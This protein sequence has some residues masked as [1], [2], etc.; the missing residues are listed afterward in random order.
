MEKKMDKNIILNYY[1]EF[2]RDYRK[3][4][5]ADIMHIKYAEHKII[6]DSDKNIVAKKVDKLISK[7]QLIESMENLADFASK[8]NAEIVRL[9]NE[10]EKILINGLVKKVDVTHYYKKELDLECSV[11]K[12]SINKNKKIIDSIQKPFLPRDCIKLD[13]PI[14]P[15]QT[16]FIP[17]YNFIQK[18]LPFLKSLENNK[19]K[20]EYEIAYQSY[21]NDYIDIDKLNKVEIVR[22]EEEDRLYK[23]KLFKYNNKI[24]RLQAMLQEEEEEYSKKMQQN[25]KKIYDLKLNLSQKNKEA[26]E[27]YIS[28][29]LEHSSYPIDFDKNIQINFNP[30]LLV[31]DY[32]LPSIDTFPSVAE[33]KFLKGHCTAIP[34][35]EK[36][37]S[38]RY[39]NTLYQI[40]LRTLYEIFVDNNLGHCNSI[41]F[42]GWVQALNKANGKIN[43]SCIL[44]IQV[45]RE[46]FLDIDFLNVSSK[47]CFKALKG[48]ACS[49]LS[50]ITAIKPIVTLNKS[51][52]RF[53]EHYDVDGENFT[54]LALMHW[55]DFEHLI[56]ELFEKEFS[57]SGGEVKVTRASRDGGVDAVVFD[58]DPIRGGKLVIQAK[59]YT[60]TVGVSAVRDLFGTVL[61]EG[62][63]KGILVTTSDYGADSYEFAK[64]KP[65]TLMNGANLLYLLEKHGQHARIDINEA[66][67][68]MNKEK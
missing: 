48:I 61:N 34:M 41:V 65:I 46:Q 27:E 39:D 50:T 3:R 9:N 40:T 47:A 35:K 59:R 36:V 24:K 21:E 28:L 44:S 13:F 31:V 22:F 54:N 16:D 38:E 52:K 20:K 55:E 1:E 66:K 60:N 4:Y 23:E 18:L 8:K 67:I 12:E 43:R 2:S 45:N 33:M 29:L 14:E 10:I 63:T 7:W 17:K 6:K 11:L 25:K 32:L 62:A 68:L 64:D 5:V 51:D 49:Q 19:K 30:D 56:R 42:N 26:I 58:P 53:V 57:S 37:F 15:Q